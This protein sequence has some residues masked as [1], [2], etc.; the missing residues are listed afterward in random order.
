MTL[1]AVYR[2]QL[3]KRSESFIHAQASKVPRYRSLYVGRVCMGTAPLDADFVLPQLS[4]IGR[5]MQSITR[6]PDSFVDLLNGRDVRLMHAHFGIEGV[7][8]AGIAARL[9]VPLVTTF[10]G[11]DATLSLK[12]LITSGK[13]SLLNYALHRSRL[14]QRGSLFIC[15]SDFIRQRVLHL[16][17]PPSRTVVHYIGIDTTAIQPPIERS[18]QPSVLHVARLVEKKGTADLITAF[19]TV[20]RS[21]P[22]A[23]LLIVG[24]GPLEPVLRAQTR[25]L[26][27]G[28]A[29]SFLGAQPN[30]AVLQMMATSWVFCLPSV[31]AQ[32][33][34]S[35]GLAIVLLEAAASG[36]PVVAT[37]HGGIAEA[38]EH[39]RTGFLHPEHDADGLASSLKQLL[40]D[41]RLRATMGNHARRRVM[42]D[43]DIGKQSAALAELYESLR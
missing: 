37:R 3:F 39:E 34:D 35:E 27:I 26:G 10:H 36:M 18:P 12:A 15:V 29:V 14:A 31:T 41:Q 32:S 9:D 40:L 25:D 4:R 33:G 24:E 43:F 19:A 21:V 11:F 30:E 1:V 23:K 2:H 13:A 42:Q 20:L 5:A 28:N 6:R 17:F 22:E 8:A 38:V 7:Y 16:G